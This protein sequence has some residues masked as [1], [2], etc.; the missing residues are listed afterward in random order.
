[1][2]FNFKDGALAFIKTR[3]TGTKTNS[4]VLLVV[5][6]LF[7]MSLWFL[8]SAVLPDMMREVELSSFIQAYLS[9]SV[10]IGFV[11]GAL[12]IAVFGIADRFDAR[13]IFALSAFFAAFFNY[14]LLFLELGGI[15]SVLARGLTGV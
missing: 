5:A 7:T 11:I 9:S 2:V 12:L 1:M 4:I 14:S 6:E 13:K 10:N 8:S 15:A 3:L